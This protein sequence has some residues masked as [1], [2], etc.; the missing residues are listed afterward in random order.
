[1]ELVRLNGQDYEEWLQVLNAVF[2]RKNNRPMDF[3]KELPKMCVPD[4]RHMGKHLAVKEDGKIVSV[5]GIYPIP[6]AVGGEELLFSTVGNVATLPEYEGRGYMQLLLEKAMEELEN[7]GA[8]AS[9]LGGVRQRYNRF[10]YESC[11]T[12]YLFA[13]NT[14]CR[15]H[16]M[17]PTTPQ[18][19]FREVSCDDTQA[20][21]QINAMYDASPIRVLRAKEDGLSGVYATLTAWQNTPYLAVLENGTAVGYLS[22]SADGCS[23]AEIRAD[24]LELLKAVVFRWQERVG[25]DI[26]ITFPP[27]ETEAVRYFSRVASG[28]SFSPPCHFKFLRYDRV[29]NAL[30]KLKR[31]TVPGLPVGERVIG[32]AG[33]GNL[34]LYAGEDTAGCEKTEES[35]ALTLEP[36]QANRI[37]FGP[38]SFDAQ[39]AYDPFLSA[40]LPLPLSWNTLDRV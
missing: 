28:M 7:I 32:I 23:V 40:W 34:R 24:N 2:S 1:M 27:L 37:L 22:V 8:D 19:T 21:A 3:Q 17:A 25:K 20:L 9:R 35:A 36:L 39:L 10:G 26:Y 13:V 33:F 6:V 12:E 11:G 4:D 30:M 16:C 31:E 29:V 18:I 15:Q 14:H 5:V 38:L